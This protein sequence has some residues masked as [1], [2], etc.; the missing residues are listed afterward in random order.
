MPSSEMKSPPPWQPAYWRKDRKGVP[1]LREEQIKRMVEE[2]KISTEEGRRLME[3]LERSRSGEARIAMARD[4]KKKRKSGKLIMIAVLVVTAVVAAGLALGLYFGLKGEETAGDLFEQGEHAFMEG[5]YAE[6]ARLYESGLSM[7]PDS[8]VVYNLLGMAHR[9]QYNET[10]NPEYRQKELEA[11]RKAVQ[12]QPDNPV[13]LVNL[14]ATLYYMDQKQEACR[15]LEKALEVYPE[16]P[17]RENIEKL[18]DGC[19]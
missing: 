12:I 14:G 4:V 5:D 19:G 2:G 18:I 11:F 13:Q 10:G 1:P 15:Y 16:H 6:A 7:D 8:A 9:F 17:D 3:A